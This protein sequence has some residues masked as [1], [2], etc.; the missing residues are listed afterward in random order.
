MA[1]LSLRA[2]QKL[3]CKKRDAWWTVVLVDPI[4]TRMLIVMARFKF[5]TPN[6]VTWAALFV[7]LGSAGF[8]SRAT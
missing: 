8:S 7:G 6:R 5:I 2:V 4:A 1:K 3:T